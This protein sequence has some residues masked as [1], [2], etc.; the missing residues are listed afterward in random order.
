M[1]SEMRAVP[2]RVQCSVCPLRK[3]RQFRPFTDEEL[4][5]VAQFKRGELLAAPGTSILTEGDRSEHLYTVLSGWA[6]R[7]KTLEDGRRQ[8]LNF[9]VPGDLVG[10]QG[11]LTAEM[12]HSVEALT[13][14][15]LCIF[16]RRRLFGLYQHHSGL[17][18][19]LTWLA[20]REETILDEHL[21]SV[22]RRSALE[23]AAYLLG[24]LH[25]RARFSGQL[26]NGN[27]ILPVTQA[28]VAD[29]LGLS[30]VH[31]NKTL[32]KLADKGLIRWLDRGCEIL[33][34]SGLFSVAGWEPEDA[35]LRPFI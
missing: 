32:R 11:A 30:I 3:L 24:F 8:V 12:Q 34:K 23:R 10:L 21:L 5:F 13:P 29:T 25:E 26:E 14:L 2:V 22:G 27:L 15:V 20:A 18:F 33:D 6:F 17:A 7:Y 35:L 31:T 16:E 4:D 19:D 1:A 28:L 9:L